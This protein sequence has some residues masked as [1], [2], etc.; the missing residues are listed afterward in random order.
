MASRTPLVVWR[1]TGSYVG[2]AP[3]RAISSPTYVYHNT[4]QNGRPH[5]EESSVY[6]G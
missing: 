5:E 1:A 3:F 2:A 4:L 6:I